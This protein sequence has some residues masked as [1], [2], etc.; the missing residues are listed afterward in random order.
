M[1]KIAAYRIGNLFPVSFWVSSELALRPHWFSHLMYVEGE[2]FPPGLSRRRAVFDAPRSAGTPHNAQSKDASGDTFDGATRVD[3]SRDLQSLN[4]HTANVGC[5]SLTDHRQYPD[6]RIS[7]LS[8]I[9]LGCPV[10]LNRKSASPGESS[11]RATLPTAVIAFHE[12]NR[13]YR[14]LNLVW[15]CQRSATLSIE[16]SRSEQSV[17]THR[18]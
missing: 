2:S 13:D 15:Q 16:G 7:K 11:A 1:V 17:P 12:L 14:I 4:S 5:A 18:H 9:D 6:G 3:Q 10:C 8:A